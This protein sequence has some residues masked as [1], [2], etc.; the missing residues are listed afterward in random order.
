MRYAIWLPAGEIVLVMHYDEG[1]NRA[2]IE[3][4]DGRHETVSAGGIRLL[5]EPAYPRSESY[6]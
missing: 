2:I 4:C 3:R 5:E 1:N 6:P